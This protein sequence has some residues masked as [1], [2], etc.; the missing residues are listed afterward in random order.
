MYKPDQL[1]QLGGAQH[2]HMHARKLACTS[3]L[4]HVEMVLVICHC[5][6]LF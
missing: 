6:V 3:V 2:Q 4:L 5:A 1:L